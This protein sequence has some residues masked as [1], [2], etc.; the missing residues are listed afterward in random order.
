MLQKFLEGD[1][2]LGEGPFFFKHFHLTIG[3]RPSHVN[4]D[5]NFLTPVLHLH[6]AGHLLG[7]VG[8]PNTIM[9]GQEVLCPTTSDHAVQLIR[10][11]LPSFFK[12]A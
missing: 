2:K 1:G 5:S 8:W 9:P 10:R 3:A 6:D 11:L 7:E 4:N 12:R